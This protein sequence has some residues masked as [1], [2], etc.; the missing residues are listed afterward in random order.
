MRFLRR[1]MTGLVMA[2]VTLGLLL[3][4]VQTIL[5]AMIADEGEG[6]GRVGQERVFAA[7]VLRAEAGPVTPVITVYGETRARRA[8]ELRAPAAGRVADRSPGMV[9]GGRVAAGEVLL[10]L[11]PAEATAARDLARAGLAEAEAAQDEA[12]AALALA[13]DDLAAAGAQAALRAQALERQRDLAARGVGSDAAVETAALAASA[14]GQAVLS[15]RSALAGAEA[16]VNRAGSALDRARI[17]L[18]EAERALAD[19]VLTAP[20]DGALAGVTVIP[21][22]L[23][24]PNERLGELIDPTALDV[25]FRLSAADFARLSDAAGTLPDIPVAVTLEMGETRL[26]ATGR[27]VRVSAAVAEGQTGREVFAALDAPGGLQPGDFV[28]VR[29]EEPPLAAAIDLPATAL[30][31]DGAVLVLGPED[32]LDLLPVTLLR[33]QGDRVLLAPGGLAGREVVTDRSPVL[34]QGIRVRPVR[35]GQEEQAEMIDLSPERRAALIAQVEASDRMPEGVKARL[36]AQ[37]AA[38]PVPA[39]VVAR[40]EGQGG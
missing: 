3:M 35:P 12:A 28:L 30:G 17:A 9:E 18:A 34:G 20:F 25:A 1:A 7:A 40:L 5:S 38:G 22:R 36:L 23:L 11:D 15:R 29:L 19:T 13:R 32:R 31:A 8:L 39:R 14:A 10:R 21:G 26:A 27:V 6:P 4:A 24:S 33:R 2:A 37:L 16:A